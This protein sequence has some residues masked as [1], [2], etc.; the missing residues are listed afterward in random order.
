MSSDLS[1]SDD[2]RGVGGCADAACSCCLAHAVLPFGFVEGVVDGYERFELKN[3][4]RSGFHLVGLRAMVALLLG[5]GGS[6]CVGMHLGGR[7]ACSS[8]VL[9]GVR[10]KARSEKVGH[11]EPAGLIR[12]KPER[13]TPWSTI[14]P[15]KVSTSRTRVLQ[16]RVD[17]VVT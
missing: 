10:K 9:R 11:D 7:E 3:L 2:R 17:R 1:V 16:Q 6:G 14:F 13:A 5:G 12:Y 4:I 15:P 8:D